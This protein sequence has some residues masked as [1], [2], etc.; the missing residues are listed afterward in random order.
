MEIY[1]IEETVR[2][3]SFKRQDGISWEADPEAILRP[4]DIHTHPDADEDGPDGPETPDDAFN[5]ESVACQEDIL[6]ILHR[7][8]LASAWNWRKKLMV[9]L[10]TYHYNAPL[11]NEH[12]PPAVVLI[13]CKHGIFIMGTDS[14]MAGDKAPVVAWKFDSNSENVPFSLLISEIRID[15]FNRVEC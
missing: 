5:V 11:F 6:F 4:T 1:F 2:G 8:G 7:N 10:Y 3:A 14:D 9:H 13:G 15:G 12:G